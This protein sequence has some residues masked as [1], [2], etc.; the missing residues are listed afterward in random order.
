M[1]T[2]DKE[3][4]QQAEAAPAEQQP[5]P[6]VAP[7]ADEPAHEETPSTVLRAEQALIKK[8]NQLG[9]AQTA[10][11]EAEE[12]LAAE[13]RKAFGADGAEAEAPYHRKLWSGVE[14]YQCRLC[15]F[16]T[17]DEV[18]A[19]DHANEHPEFRTGEPVPSRVDANG[20]PI[21]REEA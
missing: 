7:R 5:A 12:K 21:R 16:D 1:A 17:G 10:V 20:D 2:K 3:Q 11:L 19:R 4:Q 13:R 6:G 9:D 8:Q 14:R 15:A 18:T